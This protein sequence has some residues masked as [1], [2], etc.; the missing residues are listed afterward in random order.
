MRSPGPP[1]VNPP[2]SPNSSIPELSPTQLSPEA[3]ARLIEQMRTM[4]Q[5]NQQ[6]Q[7]Q[8]LRL[9]QQLE[10]RD[11]MRIQRPIQIGNESSNDYSTV[12]RLGFRALKWLFLFLIGFA[13]AC[14]VSASLQ[15]PQ[16]LQA[17][18]SLISTIVVPLIVL[19]LCVMV[20]AAIVESLK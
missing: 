8:L 18:M 11:R 13:I 17:L 6:M 19:I 4:Q 15:A 10:E 12:V 16:V 20:G 9:Q 5:A 7:A 3:V 1:S 14:V 2:P